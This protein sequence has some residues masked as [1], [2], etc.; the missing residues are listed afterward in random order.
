MTRTREQLAGPLYAAAGVGDLAIAKLKDLPTEYQ[1]LAEQ[2]R[3]LDVDDIRTHVENYTGR[4]RETYDELVTR[5]EK[6]VTS[7]RHQ[8]ASQDL[9]EQADNT[10]RQARSTRTRAKGTATSA[11]KTAGSAK[12]AAGGAA[13]KAG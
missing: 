8:K 4:A 10:A 12:K 3:G 6:L 1:R 9:A 2:L 13:R 7:V 5:G 11:R